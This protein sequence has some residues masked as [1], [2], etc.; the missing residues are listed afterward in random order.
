MRVPRR[1][2]MALMAYPAAYRE[3]RGPELVATLADG[4]DDRGRPSMR[5]AGALAGRGLAMRLGAAGS[6]EN[7]LVMAAA[8]VLATLLSGF[9]WAERVFLLRGEATAFG[10]DVPGFWWLA[11]LGVSAWVVLAA[12]PMGAVDDPRRRRIVVVLTLPLFLLIFTAPGRLVVYDALDPESLVEYLRLLPLYAFGSGVVELPAVAL[13]AWVA[14]KALRRLA[15]PARRRAM[16]AALALLGGVAV[17]QAWNRP[18]LPAEYG[19]SAFADLGT[20]TFL[21]AL[22]ALVALAAIVRTRPRRA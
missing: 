20:A 15:E 13:A 4:D 19:Q 18:D 16:A 9:T 17:V 6:G 11:A 22:A 1:Y 12:G 21:A 14:L 8:L 7:L 3:S 10:T 2:R 5:E